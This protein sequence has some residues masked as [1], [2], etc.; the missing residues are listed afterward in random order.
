MT[1]RRLCVSLFAPQDISS[2]SWL[3]LTEQQT[4]STSVGV[5]LPYLLI[6]VHHAE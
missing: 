5:Y 2:V 4:E 3:A 6:V 1:K